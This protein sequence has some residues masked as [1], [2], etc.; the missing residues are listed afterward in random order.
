MGSI[1]QQGFFREEIMAYTSRQ[2]IRFDDVDGAGI[3]YYP[4]FFD[5]CHAAF[6]DYFDSSTNC[7]YPDLIRKQKL[8]F[9]TVSIEST[10]SA[11]LEYGDTA[12][13]ELQ[14]ESIGTS[15]V[16][17]GYT[18]Y[19]ERDRKVCCRAKVT[20]VLVNLETMAATPLTPDLINALEPLKS[21]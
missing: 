11:P 12:L 4:K 19:R 1:V 15:S 13:V 16:E 3:V 6:E 17:F 5:L 2:K 14:I 21:A 7:S 18:I 20:T 8:G 9:P 10:F